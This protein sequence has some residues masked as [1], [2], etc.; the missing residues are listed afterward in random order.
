MIQNPGK[1]TTSH[2]FGLIEIMVVVAVVSLTASIFLPRYLREK[3]HL[4]Q[5][6]CHKNLQ[7]LSK[8]EDDYYHIHG[9]YTHNLRDL[10]WTPQDPFHQYEFMPYPIA[11]QGFLFQCVGN[12]DNDALLDHAK[13]DDKHNF[14]KIAD[15]R[16][17]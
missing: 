11:T 13:I 3:I 10:G 8:L 4:R 9:S 7:L 14:R 1:P 16:V 6:Q 15:D 12:I 17:E 5:L 2:H